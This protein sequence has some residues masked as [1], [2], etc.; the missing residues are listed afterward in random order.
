MKTIILVVLLFTIAGLSISFAIPATYQVKTDILVNYSTNI[1]T[2][3]L[4]EG[5]I[6]K[7]LSLIGTYKY[8]LQSN[9][10]LHKVNEVLKEPYDLTE[11][12]NKVRIESSRESQIISIVVQDVKAE[13]AAI[14]ANNIAYIFQQEVK[15][16]MKQE[17]VN[18]LSKVSAKGDT[19]MVKPPTVFYLL[20]SFCIGILVIIM[21]IMLKETYFT[22]VDSGEKVRKY[23]HLSNLGT[24]PF[25]KK[26]QRNRE[27]D[28]EDNLLQHF[29]VNESNS[30]VF[31]TIRANLQ[32]LMKQQNVKTLLITSSN[33]EDGKSFISANL[34]KIMAMNGKKTVY[35][36]ADLRKPRGRILFNIKNNL[37]IMSYITGY[38]TFP[39]IIQKTEFD[40]L[41]FIGAGP[42]QPNFTEILSSIQMKE[43]IEQ[44]KH[45]FDVIIIDSPPLIIA[46]T[47]NLAT[48]VDGCVLVINAQKT[49]KEHAKE[50]VNQLTKI[51]VKMIVTILNKGKKVKGKTDYY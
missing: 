21:Y 26:P 10:I 11:W 25:I 39:D 42:L 30:E 45:Q 36:D 38:S 2:T 27:M 43:I 47:L 48:I 24:I 34:A 6:N 44:L 13:K 51:K 1:S 33:S 4:S 15:N 29:G 8:F 37:G 20:I 3:S 40:H 35:I 22:I 7:N 18:V 28:Y 41:S 17:N 19:E 23:L 9:R 49:R 16:V 46:D 31:K 32:F 14:V 50:S 12:E 5:E